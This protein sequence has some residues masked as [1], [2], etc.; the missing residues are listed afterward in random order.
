[1]RIDD[2]NKCDY[3]SA[4]VDISE[5]YNNYFVISGERFKNF[6][7]C[8]PFGTEYQDRENNMA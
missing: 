3:Y 4:F 6:A 7:K 1:M 8:Q 2:I 5:C